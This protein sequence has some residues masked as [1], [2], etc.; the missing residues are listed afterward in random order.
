MLL[1]RD[2]HYV[3][4]PGECRTAWI[5]GQR[6]EGADLVVDRLWQDMRGE[7]RFDPFAYALTVEAAEYSVKGEQGTWHTVYDCRSSKPPK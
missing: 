1:L 6:I 4:R 3:I 7:D 2:V 5:D